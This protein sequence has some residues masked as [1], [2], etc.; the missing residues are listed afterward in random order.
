MTFP[1]GDAGRLIEA[2]ALSHPG[3]RQYLDGALM[4][5]SVAAL[6]AAV[7]SEVQAAVYMDEKDA[8]L[9]HHAASRND[10]WALRTLLTLGANPHQTDEQGVLAVEWAAR[11]GQREAFDLLLTHGLPMRPP[12]AAPTLVHAAVC[13]GLPFLKGVADIS[14][15]WPVSIWNGWNEHGMRPLHCAVLRMDSEAAALL[16]EMGADPKARCARGTTPEDMF[17]S[18]FPGA[19]ERWQAFLCGQTAPPAAY[20]KPAFLRR[21]MGH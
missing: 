6:Q 3:A 12:V 4:S 1:S 13:A 8:P 17:L 7:R 20:S 5:G 21:R 9:L 2:V 18:R 10:C 19:H 16:S 11:A 15:P 14:M